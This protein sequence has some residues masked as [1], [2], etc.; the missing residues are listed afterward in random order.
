MKKLNFIIIAL[1]LIFSG[2]TEFLTLEP[3]DELIREEYWKTEDDVVAVLGT[4][5]SRLGD[6]LVEIYRWSELRGGLLTKD[7]R[8]VS[9]NSLEF[10][11]YNV[12]EF[13]EHVKWDDF[14]DVINLA[15]TII[16]YAPLAKEN[17]QTFTQE[18]YDGY[19]AEA[20]FLRTISYFYLVK[21]FRDVP[22]VLKS[23]SKDDQDFNIAKTEES[24]IV[25]QLITDLN[26]VVDKAF[27][28]DHFEN[29]VD[30]KGRAN[31]NAIYAL[32][33]DL[34]LWNNDYDNCIATCDK[35]SGIYMVDG[36]K[37]FT[38]Y[39]DEGNSL[40][41][42]FELQYDYEKYETTNALY[43]IT[44]NFSQG[45]REYM[46]SEY[47]MGLYGT[48]D[49]RQYSED[50]EVTYNTEVFS[51]WKYQ[52]NAPYEENSN[53]IHRYW[54]DSDANWIF[55]RMA[56]I[57]L[58]KAEAYAEKGGSDLS[59]AIDELNIIKK[60]AG[61]DFYT[62][63]TDQEKLLNEILDERARE[64]VGEGKRWFDVVRV[65]RRDIDNRLT[66]VSNAVIA[67]VD[68]RSRSAVESKIKDMDSWF[69]PIFYNELLLNNQLKQNPFYE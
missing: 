61:V 5:Y 23:Y 8:R 40:E 44:S 48:N 57:H 13:N 31:I 29:I 68:P 24:A 27:S 46:V 26:S 41:S 21:T 6:N 47:L 25:E 58:M 33:A 17:D 14:Y 39:A 54:F 55:Y 12:N 2:C 11:N 66:I 42:I 1:V 45:D 59:K 64:L 35:I 38:L 63:N 18:A 4:T 10:F 43:D 60:R 22:F 9:P 51:L 56:E 19:L 20:Y 62:D 65:A 15:N 50:G 67:N 52:G 49:L 36:A 3:Q 34:Y 37:Y 53:V 30:K 16:E 28:P 32:L 7:E 69:L